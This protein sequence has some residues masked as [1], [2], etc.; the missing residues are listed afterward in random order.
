MFST[1]NEKNINENENMIN[2]KASSKRN[3]VV[4][5]DEEITSNTLN[6]ATA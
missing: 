2:S 4:N 6:P 5:R 1:S 3:S